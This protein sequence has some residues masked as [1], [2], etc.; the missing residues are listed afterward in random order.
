M[1]QKSQLD[2]L[3]SG[4]VEI[5]KT[6]VQLLQKRQQWEYPVILVNKWRVTRWTF[7]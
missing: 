6:N 1:Q 3:A 7:F 5:V 2:Q 4:E